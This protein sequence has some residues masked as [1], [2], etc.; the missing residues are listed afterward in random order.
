MNAEPGR[1]TYVCMVRY[2]PACADVAVVLEGQVSSS[3]MRRIQ[4]GMAAVTKLLSQMLAAAQ[5]S[6]TCA[7]PALT[8]LLRTCIQINEEPAGSDNEMQ[9]TT[10]RLALS[11]GHEACKSQQWCLDHQLRLSSSVIRLGPRL[12]YGSQMASAA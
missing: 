4:G 10:Y 1:R 2:A 5:P 12:M 7:E 8:Q 3:S 9:V 11:V 6:S